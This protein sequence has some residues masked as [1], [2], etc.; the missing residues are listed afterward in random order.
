MRPHDDA[1][2]KRG[3]VRFRDLPYPFD[4]HW[5]E[6]GGVRTCWVGEG[7][8]VPV[9]LLCPA[10]RGLLHYRE[11]FKRRASRRFIALDLPGWGKADKPDLP[12]DLPHYLAWLRAFITELGLERPHLVGNSLGGQL[13]ANLAAH[14]PE[15]FR[16]LSLIAIPGAMSTLRKLLR[17]LLLNERSIRNMQPWQFRRSVKK[18]FHRWP[19]RAE[20]I[21]A[22][23]VELAQGPD[24]P[25]YARSLARCMRAALG[26]EMGPLLGMLDGDEGGDGRPPVQFLWGRHDAVCPLSGLDTLAAHVPSAA[27]H[28]IEECGHYPPVESPDDTLRLLEAFWDTAEAA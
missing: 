15:R 7:D 25:P 12:Y 17:P 28:I 20:E 13:A 11:L 3:P 18:N 4:E 6:L 21:V 26:Q 9:L 8:G 19:D 14:E 24:W 10:G 22:K 1:P 5:I 16:S 23:G 2:H 27:R